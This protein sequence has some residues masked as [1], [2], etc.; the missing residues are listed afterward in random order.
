MNFGPKPGGREVTV[1]ELA[2]LGVE[3]LGAQPWR[4]EH[5]PTSI[6]AKSLAIDATLAKR[7]LGFESRLDAP[8]A[9]ALTMEWY[10]RQANGEAAL[11][12]CREQVAA[13]EGQS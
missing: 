5:D 11:G 2:S 1:G 7:T 4:H 9:V 8:R 12:L 6:E 10:R 3:A 13:Y